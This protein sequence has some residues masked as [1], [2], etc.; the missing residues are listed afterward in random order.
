MNLKIKNDQTNLSTPILV[1]SGED[2]LKYNWERLKWHLHCVNR[3]EKPVKIL[4]NNTK[5][6][7][8]NSWNV[9]YNTN[10]LNISFNIKRL[11]KVDLSSHRNWEF[12]KKVTTASKEYNSEASQLSLIKPEYQGKVRNSLCYNADKKCKTIHL[13]PPNEVI[14]MIKWLLT[15]INTVAIAKVELNQK[16]RRRLLTSAHTTSSSY[17]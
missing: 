11:T 15:E 2:E 8:S 16:K 17:T 6:S 9:A 3:Q 13:Q 7:G 4:S 1:P 10:P 12:T 14:W 5:I